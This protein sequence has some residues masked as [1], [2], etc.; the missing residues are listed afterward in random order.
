MSTITFP[1]LVSVW[2]TN[3]QLSE[4]LTLTLDQSTSTT[5]QWPTGPASFISFTGT[6]LQ[7]VVVNGILTDITG[8]TFTGATL[9][10]SGVTESSITDW[11]VSAAAFFDICVT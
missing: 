11:S 4:I 6:G 8:G 2:M 9:V 3:F 7:P 1:G 10:Y 5:L